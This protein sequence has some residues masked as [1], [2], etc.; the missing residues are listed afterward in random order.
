[1]CLIL[2]CLVLYC[3]VRGILSPVS[4]FVVFSSCFAGFVAL[5]FPHIDVSASV[6]SCAMEHT[7][8]PFSP[9]KPP[10]PNYMLKVLSL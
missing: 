3:L 2:Y 1:M 8:S 6:F 7:F 4:G 10:E 5:L 9:L